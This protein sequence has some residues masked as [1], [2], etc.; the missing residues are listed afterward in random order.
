MLAAAGAVLARARRTFTHLSE[1]RRV[2]ER[3]RGGV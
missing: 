1:R 3:E 2:L